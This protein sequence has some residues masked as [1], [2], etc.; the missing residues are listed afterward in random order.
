MES[1]CIA[2]MLGSKFLYLLTTF[3][4]YLTLLEAKYLHLC[5][6]YLPGYPVTYIG[7]SMSYARQFLK[8]PGVNFNMLQTIMVGLFGNAFL[9]DVKKANRSIFLWTVNKESW[10]KWSIKK[11]VDGVITDD[12]KKYLEVCE[13]YEDEKIHHSLWA[14]WFVIWVNLLVPFFSLLFRYK[15]GFRID[16]KK[17]RKSL[18][19]SNT[20]PSA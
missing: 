13:N 6:K 14:W 2:G 3:L 9:R 18:E 20:R 19:S 15:Y 12:P 17:V 1:A 11:E 8:V 4:Q 16:A 7:F 10:M 5:T